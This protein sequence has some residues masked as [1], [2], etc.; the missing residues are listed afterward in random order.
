MTKLDKGLMDRDLKINFI[1]LIQCRNF[2]FYIFLFYLE[3][4]EFNPDVSENE[5]K[6][7]E[8]SQRF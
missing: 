1:F 6:L 5:G 4:I 2:Y 3:A 8:V 7:C